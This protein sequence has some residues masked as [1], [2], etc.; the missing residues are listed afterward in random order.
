MHSSCF[1]SRLKF[2][3]P[4][5]SYK[6]KNP[7]KTPCLLSPSQISHLPSPHTLSLLYHT[8]MASS[9]EDILTLYSTNT[10]PQSELGKLKLKTSNQLRETISTGVGKESG[11]EGTGV[12]CVPVTLA[13]DIVALQGLYC[14]VAFSECFSRLQAAQSHS[15]VVCWLSH[16]TLVG[17][18]CQ[19]GVMS[20]DEMMMSRDVRECQE[21]VCVGVCD[22]WEQ[23]FGRCV[24]G[25]LRTVEPSLFFSLSPSPPPLPLPLPLPLPPLLLC[26]PLSPLPLSL[27][28]SH[29]HTLTSQ[30]SPSTSSYYSRQSIALSPP[31]LPHKATRTWRHQTTTQRSLISDLASHPH[32]HRGVYVSPDT[33][34]SGRESTRRPG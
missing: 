27:S 8:A 19:D 34:E 20:G 22:D 18:C 5:G 4:V 1:C 30:V 13:G 14:R 25:N 28:L 7:H 2:T 23:T 21:M 12:S 15:S 9:L 6:P 33:P 11:V 32:C 17:D 26:L 29:T 31:S 10:S 3:F 24:C 16:V